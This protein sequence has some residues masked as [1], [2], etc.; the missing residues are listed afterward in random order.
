VGWQAEAD[1]SAVSTGVMLLLT[2]AVAGQP[3]PSAS[4]SLKVQQGATQDDQ[5]S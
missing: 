2:L 5:T 4:F 1:W 3:A